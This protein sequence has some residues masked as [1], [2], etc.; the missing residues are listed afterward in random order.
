MAEV[1]HV[2]YETES[3]LDARHVIGSELTHFVTHFI[4]EHVHLADEVCQFT[5][6]DFHRA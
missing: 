2:E 3:R 5:C 4:I 1:C 6:I